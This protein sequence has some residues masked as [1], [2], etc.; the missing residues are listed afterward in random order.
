MST[1]VWFQSLV[2]SAQVHIAKMLDPST[3]LSAFAQADIDKDERLISCPFNLAVTPELAG[4]AI[5]AIESL[6][7]DELVW[8]A[9]TSRA[10]EKWNDRMRI[11]A[12]IGLH[13]VRTDEEGEE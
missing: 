9:G 7:E 6:K 8:L 11:G 10:G 2:S 5:C 1:L 13:W 12:Y 3:G 4:E